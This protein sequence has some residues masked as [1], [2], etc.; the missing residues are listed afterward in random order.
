[1]ARMTGH[2]YLA[3]AMKAYEGDYIFHMPTIVLP[4]FAEMEG[5]GIVRGST[6]S[7]KSAVYMADGYARASGKPGIAMAQTV[8]AA[9]MAAGLQDPY[10]ASAPVIAITGGRLPDTKFRNVYQE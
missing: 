2:R 1:M 6:H 9:N 7:E 3:E 4:A 10:L 5:M 8:G